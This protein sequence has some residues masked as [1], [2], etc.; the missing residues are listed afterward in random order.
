MYI[1]KIE[2]NNFRNYEELSLEFD[3]NVNFILGDNAQGKTNLLEA[4]FMSS[5]AKSF[6]TSKDS[7]MIGFDKDFC[8]IKVYAERN[9]SPID[10]EISI[11]R[12]FGK[13]IKVNGVNVNRTSE[14]LKN[15]YIVVFSPEDLKIVKD[16]PEKR[17]KFID[18]ELSLIKPLYYDSLSNYKKILTQRNI[19]LKEKEIEPSMLDI[20][21]VQL[22]SY[23]A[24][25]ISMRRKFIKKLNDISRNIHKNITGGKENITVNYDPN[26][27]EE[28]NVEEKLY[29]KIKDSLENDLRMR[30]TTRGPH[31]DDIQFFIDGINVRNYGS[32]GQQRTAA[33]SLKLAEIDLIKEE[34]GENAVLLLDDVMSELDGSRQEFLIKY[35]SDVQL[36]ITAAEINES[37]KKLSENGSLFTVENGKIL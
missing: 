22:S 21:D 31:R 20:W 27:D 25:I 33:L 15:I 6:R 34:T 35:L 9:V 32:Q 2:L 28:E 5:I 29:E 7:D 36:F 3:K 37:L 4:I 18:R 17:R 19:Y 30:T 14:L 10:V 12:D 23:G 11:K 1:K 16:E 26:V 24:K 8:R 13:F